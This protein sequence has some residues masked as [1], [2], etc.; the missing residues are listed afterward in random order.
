[1]YHSVSTLIEK[2]TRHI[3]YDKLPQDK[4]HICVVA[5]SDI[6]GS[7]VKTEMIFEG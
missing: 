4:T 6:Y 3:L 7:S 5:V 1:M 2:L